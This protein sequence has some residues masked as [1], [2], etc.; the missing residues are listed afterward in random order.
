MQKYD[1]KQIINNFYYALEM[2][3]A[4]RRKA[5]NSSDEE[6][7]CNELKRF[8]MVAKMKNPGA[9]NSSFART[10]GDV[11]S[12]TSGSKAGGT[13]KGAAAAPVVD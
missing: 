8:E 13:Q 2:S 1:I 11:L 7:G 3:K 9:G 5:D 12:R 10:G 6:G 4:A